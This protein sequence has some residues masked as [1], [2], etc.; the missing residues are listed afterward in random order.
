MVSAGIA[1]IALLCTLSVSAEAKKGGSA[2]ES[3]KGGKRGDTSDDITVCAYAADYGVS[4]L[5]NGDEIWVQANASQFLSASDDGIVTVAAPD[6]GSLSMDDVMMKSVE[7]PYELRMD[8]SKECQKETVYKSVFLGGNTQG[9]P[10]FD[11]HGGG[12]GLQH[13]DAHFNLVEAAVQAA[14]VCADVTTVPIQ[15]DTASTDSSNLEFLEFPDEEQLTGFYLDDTFGGHAIIGHGTHWTAIEDAELG[16]TTPNEGFHWTDC[17]ML[18]PNCS[19]VPMTLSNILLTYG[20]DIVS[21]ELMF[22]SDIVRSLWDTRQ[23]VTG[24]NGTDTL[25][26]SKLYPHAEKV[27]YRKSYVQKSFIEVGAS[28]VVRAGFTL[29]ENRG[30]SGKFS[31]EQPLDGATAS[32]TTKSAVIGSAA[33]LTVGLIAAVA[34]KWYGRRA[35]NYHNPEAE[36]ILP[37]E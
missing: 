11:A 27:K 17:A 31:A 5:Y 34:K 20:G 37:Q 13:Y 15:C 32:I 18:N 6:S 33:V 25:E 29:Q 24:N 30:K 28:D 8:L 14:Y 12:Y 10:P 2:S 4:V 26:I 3:G 22:S 21:H 16:V 1:S 19:F 23:G 9:H 36:Y 35:A 7:L